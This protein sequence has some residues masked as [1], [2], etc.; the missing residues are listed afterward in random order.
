MSLFADMPGFRVSG[1][2]VPPNVMA[3]TEKP[4]IVLH[5]VNE[6]VQQVVLIE[7]TVP[8]EPNMYRARERK[9]ERYCQLNNDIKAKNIE[10]HLIC[11]E[12]GSRG[13]ISKENKQQIK[14]IFR[15]V[16]EKSCK[17]IITKLSQLALIG[18]YVIFNS[19]SDPAWT[20][21]TLL[22]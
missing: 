5:L 16:G 12:V 4:D 19:R 15:F 22:D 21:M 17:G 1:G 10:S 3:T 18:S 7:L 9:L 11:F 8:F 2:T 13:V 14:K 6:D 20:D